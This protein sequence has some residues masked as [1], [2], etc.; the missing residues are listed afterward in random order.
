MDTEIIPFE[1]QQEAPPQNQAE[2]MEAM[3]EAA[4]YT[5]KTGWGKHGSIKKTIEGVRSQRLWIDP[6]FPIVFSDEA[7]SQARRSLLLSGQQNAIHVIE[8]DNPEAKK[9]S[10]DGTTDQNLLIVDIDGALIFQ[11]AAET[12]IDE[13]D[14]EVE[15]YD[16]MYYK[17]MLRMTNMKTQQH[18]LRR[19][20]KG[21][22]YKRT[23]FAYDSEQAWRERTGQLPLPKFPS[24]KELA[25]QYDCKSES[26]LSLCISMSEFDD[27]TIEL[28][29]SGKLSEDQLRE[30]ASANS[31]QRKAIA[32]QLAEK[33]EETGKPAT[34]EET[35]QTVRLASGKIPKP[36]RWESMT[37]PVIVSGFWTR[38]TEQEE[39]PAPVALG[40]LMHDVGACLDATEEELPKEA[41]GLV[42]KIRSVLADP[43]MQELINGVRTDEEGA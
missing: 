19:V 26:E 34:R 33:A 42:K 9:R 28:A 30:L 32:M 36:V 13:F 17:I 10:H 23:R 37:R 1:K 29:E 25:P 12:T 11:C 15:P 20:D 4:E 24:L 31:E 39:V 27:E 22:C 43:A 16:G 5:K 18:K 40:C 2:Y 8:L 21:R 7:L 35:R 3:I 38:N 6:N 14:V 41:R